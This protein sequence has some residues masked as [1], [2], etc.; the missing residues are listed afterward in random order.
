MPTTGNN[1]NGLW[2]SDTGDSETHTRL[3]ISCEHEYVFGGMVGPGNKASSY[4]YNS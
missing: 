4:T 2:T 1:T 3:G